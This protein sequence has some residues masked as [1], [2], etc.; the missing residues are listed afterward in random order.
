LSVSG[1]VRLSSLRHWAAVAWLVLG[2]PDRALQV[3]NDLIETFGP[4]PGWMASRAHLL[5]QQGRHAEAALDYDWLC[6]RSEARAADWFN[7]GF[8]LEHAGDFE[9]AAQSFERAVQLDSDLDRAWYGLGLCRVR[10]GQ[11]E[12]AIE[13]LLRNTQLQ[14]MS[15]HGWVQLARIHEQRQEPEEVLKIIRHL[16]GFEP[17]VAAELMRE[18]GV[19]LHPAQ[20]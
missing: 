17:K 4:R 11:P 16:Q 6:Q 8:L 1:S 9:A 18:T 5:A 20:A 19:G 10:L 2:R 15:P 7:R 12:Q 14:P 13:A 3:W